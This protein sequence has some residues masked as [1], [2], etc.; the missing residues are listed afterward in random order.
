[1]PTASLGTTW[2][3][4]CVACPSSRSGILDQLAGKKKYTLNQRGQH[5]VTN[6]VFWT[7][8]QRGKGA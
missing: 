6:H 1:M 2:P 7:C 8:V 3:A 4:A 5:T